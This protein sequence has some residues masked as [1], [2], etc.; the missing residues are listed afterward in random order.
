MG[1]VRRNGDGDGYS[2]KECDKAETTIKRMA[3]GPPSDFANAVLEGFSLP[4]VM[5][6][7]GV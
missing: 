4:I 6:G 2:M 1:G 5:K 7:S 3:L